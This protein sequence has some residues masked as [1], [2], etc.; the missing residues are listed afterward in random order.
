MKWST[1]LVLILLIVVALVASVAVYVIYFSEAP[2]EAE[3]LTFLEDVI[4]IDVS[5]YS[6]TAFNSS[7]TYPDSLG[8]LEQLTGKYAL[9]SE[10]S[11]IDVPFK[12]RNGALSWCVVRNLEGQPQYIESQ[13]DD[14]KD[15]VSLFLQKYQQYSGDSDL[16]TLKNMLDD[17]NVAKNST[18][19]TGNMKLILTVTSLSAS[20]D[21]RYTSNG[22]EY[23]KLSVSFRDGHFYSFSVNKP[24]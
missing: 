20:F 2:A 23:S 19:T 11:K 7:V 13:T 8:G 3:V 9:E 16:E 18:T 10:T 21:W 4:G 22:T 24:F 1:K 17:V 6:V 15:E 14:I 5:K 12:L